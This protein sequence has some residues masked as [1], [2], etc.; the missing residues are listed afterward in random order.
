MILYMLWWHEIR[1]DRTDTHLHIRTHTHAYTHAHT[2]AH[3]HSHTHTRTHTHTYIRTLTC[4]NSPLL[5]QVCFLCVDCLMSLYRTADLLTAKAY[6]FF[7]STGKYCA[8]AVR[9]RGPNQFTF[10]LFQEKARKLKS[11]DTLRNAK[12]PLS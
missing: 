7:P 10:V 5:I 2:Y 6:D 1:L 3:I 11:N 9:V 8:L 12:L 4:L